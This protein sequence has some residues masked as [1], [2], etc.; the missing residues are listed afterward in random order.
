MKDVDWV[1]HVKCLWT[2]CPFPGPKIDPNY[3]LKH[4][5]K[6]IWKVEFGVYLKVLTSARSLQNVMWVIIEIITR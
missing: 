1:M 2:K 5:I 6:E 3:H 4:L